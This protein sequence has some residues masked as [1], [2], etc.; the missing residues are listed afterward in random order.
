MLAAIAAAAA[1]LF[2]FLPQWTASAWAFFSN[3]PLAVWLAR[4][5]FPNF[6][7]SPLWITG[8][9]GT[10]LLI[11][12]LLSIRNDKRKAE[13]RRSKHLTFLLVVYG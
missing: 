9:I 11:M 4:Q 8:P 12:I 1:F 10:V 3:E 6:P 13:P 5:H 2:I 7:F